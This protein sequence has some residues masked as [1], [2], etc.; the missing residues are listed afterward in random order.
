V[1]AYQVGI[2]SGALGRGAAIALCLFPPLFV[3]MILLL[4]NL[5]RREY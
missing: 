5:K 3:F 4:R 2:Q 1:L